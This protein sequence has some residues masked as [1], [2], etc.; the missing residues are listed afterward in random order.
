MRAPLR[1]LSF[2]LLAPLDW[3]CAPQVTPPREAA[4][5]GATPTAGGS[6][7]RG[8][9]ASPAVTPAATVPTPPDTTRGREL[10]LVT[11]SLDFAVVGDTRPSY[12]DDTRGYPGATI[13]SIYQS[14]ERENPRPAFTVGTGDY[15]FATS[16]GHQALPQLDLYMDAR[17]AFSG[18]V[19]LAMGNHECTGLTSSNCGGEA[20]DGAP[21]PYLA[22]LDRVLTPMG[23]STPWYS[24]RVDAKDASWSAKFVFI[25][26]NAWNDEQADWLDRVLN[27]EPTTYTFAV[28]HE[29]ARWIA[30]PGVKPSN[31]ALDDH[32]PTLALVGHVHT[33][34]RDA[35]GKELVVGNGGAPLTSTVGFGYVLAHRRPDGA[36]EF[37]SIRLD[38]HEEI[39]RFAVNADGSPAD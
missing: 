4:H 35:N 14:I 21:R 27:D 16:F 30:A 1:L 8:N 15:V 33:Y 13:R 2:V 23:L 6:A 5:A 39:E 28:R 11:E 17:S 25:A 19:Y 29:G 12:P 22:Y 31:R 38:G 18:P 37:R 20:R 7:T 10:H 34:R 36:V 32:P 9:P 3:A 24:L 26:P